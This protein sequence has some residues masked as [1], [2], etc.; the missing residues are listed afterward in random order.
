VIVRTESLAGAAGM[1]ADLEEFARERM[2]EEGW[3]LVVCLADFPLK[4]GLRPVTAHASASLGAGIVS[5]P[6]LGAVS[7]TKR[8]E[9]AVSRTIDALLRKGTARR[10]AHRTDGPLARIRQRLED[11][12]ELST[13]VGRAFEHEQG[14]V[15][16]AT[17]TM[18]GNLRLLTGTIRRNRPWRLIIGLSHSLVAALGTSAFGLTSPVIWRIADVMIERRLV[19]LSIA[20]LV[21]MGITLIAAH[22]LWEP[23]P[24]ADARKRVALINLATSFTVAIG[25]LV[26][27]VVLFFLNALFGGLLIARS[28]LEVEVRHSVT[29]DN[30]L[31][32]A[33]LVSSLATFGGA[34]GAVVASNVSVREAA[35]CIRPNERRSRDSTS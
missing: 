8:A 13:P 5:V 3:H 14:T 16:F 34:L 21:A 1:S 11:L 15:R 24:S 31:R 2:L 9:M 22:G 32:I 19:M 25:V 18:R 20:S 23:T 33:W 10:R 29:F 35:S 26:P 12:K 6:A 28:V 27:Y 7:V 4:V 30:Y 17:A